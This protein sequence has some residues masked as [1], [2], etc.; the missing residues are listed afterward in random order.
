MEKQFLGCWIFL[1]AIN[2]T[3]FSISFQI[4]K[5]IIYE[6]VIVGFSEGSFSDFNV[7]THK[8][9]VAKKIDG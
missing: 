1:P 3:V 9:T 5:L 6:N 2:A 7:C 4:I 8:N